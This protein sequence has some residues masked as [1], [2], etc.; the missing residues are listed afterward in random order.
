MTFEKLNSSGKG[1]LEIQIILYQCK[2]LVKNMGGAQNTIEFNCRK[3]KLEK[4]V[5]KLLKQT[6]Q[7]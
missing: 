5:C 1:L 3:R 4:N 7:C 6:K 2:V